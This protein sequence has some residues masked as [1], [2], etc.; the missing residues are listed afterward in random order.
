[1]AAI[2]PRKLVLDFHVL[3]IRHGR[4]ICLPRKPRCTECVLLDACPEGQRR[5]GINM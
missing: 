4:K 1:L 3:L 5:L 2:V